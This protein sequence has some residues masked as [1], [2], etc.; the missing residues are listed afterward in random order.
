MSLRI[1]FMGT[2]DFSVPVLAEIIGQGHE[3]VGVYTRPPAPARRG[4]ALQTVVSRENDPLEPAVVT[5]GSIHGGTKHNIIP[6]EVK[7]QLTVRSYSPEVREK[8]LA[9]IERIAKAEAAAAGAPTAPKNTTA[10]PSRP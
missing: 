6:D 1:V 7:L 8:L 3:V 10:P 4:M 5:V 2:P 9:S